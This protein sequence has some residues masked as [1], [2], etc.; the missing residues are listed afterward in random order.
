MDEITRRMRHIT[1]ELQEMQERLQDALL[2]GPIG[3]E[4]IGPAG[5]PVSIEEVKDFKTG[6]DQMRQFLWFFVE[7]VS[8]DDTGEKLIQLLRHAARPDSR[9]A[10]TLDQMSSAS[11]YAI[12]HCPIPP[13]R[14]PN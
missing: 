10:S 8:D 6:I 11:D 5:E 7:A 12:L 9:A 13:N 2:E 3:P 4:N 1:E 14:K